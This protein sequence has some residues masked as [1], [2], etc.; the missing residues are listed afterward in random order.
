[1]WQ[2]GPHIHQISFL[3]IIVFDVVYMLLPLNVFVLKLQ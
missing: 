1:M 3:F 2:F